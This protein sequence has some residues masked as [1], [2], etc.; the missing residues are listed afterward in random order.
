MP[1]TCARAVGGIAALSAHLPFP[2]AACSTYSQAQIKIQDN[3]AGSTD[4]IISISGTPEAVQLAHYLIQQR[5]DEAR[6]APGA[7]IP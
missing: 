6:N 7:Q 1:A 4:R 3:V 2:L 5:V